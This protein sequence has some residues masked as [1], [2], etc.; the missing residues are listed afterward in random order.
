MAYHQQ[1]RCLSW[2]FTAMI[3]HRDQKEPGD[4]R[5][6]SS[7]QMGG[8]NPSLKEAKAGI[9]SVE[10]HSLLVCSPRLVQASLFYNTCPGTAPPTIR[11]A[12]P[13]QLLI[14]KIAYTTGNLMETLSQLKFIFPDNCSLYQDDKKKERK[15][16]QDKNN[17]SKESSEY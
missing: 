7:S 9:E 16:K 11:W 3:K 4:K 17:R 12:C 10:E 2:G 5:V 1:R 13:H 15:K 8:Q 6:C 14:K